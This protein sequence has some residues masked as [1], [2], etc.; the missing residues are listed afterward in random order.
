MHFISIIYWRNL[1]VQTSDTIIIIAVIVL[2]SYAVKLN[3]KY[4]TDTE[5]NQLGTVSNVAAVTLKADG[6]KND[7]ILLT[8]SDLMEYEIAFVKIEAIGSGNNHYHIASLTDK[9]G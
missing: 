2:V 5:A 3:G 4:L 7:G 9:L 8:A 6:A 1:T